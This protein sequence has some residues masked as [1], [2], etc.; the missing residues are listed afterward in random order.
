M[1]MQVDSGEAA[2]WAAELSAL[3]QV[4]VRHFMISASW[5]REDHDL[6]VLRA[7]LAIVCALRVPPEHTEFMHF[8]ATTEV[9]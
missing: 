6:S 1:C 9:C 3:Q 8:T 4:R 5:I 2:R 7:S